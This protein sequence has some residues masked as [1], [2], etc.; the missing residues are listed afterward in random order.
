MSKHSPCSGAGSLPSKR[1]MK[2]HDLWDSTKKPAL[3]HLFSPVAS[4][5]A[6]PIVIGELPVNE[7]SPSGTGVPGIG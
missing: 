5:V 7:L 4:T 6:S 1:P 2:S 3:P